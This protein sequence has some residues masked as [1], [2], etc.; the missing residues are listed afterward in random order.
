MSRA[1]RKPSKAPVRRQAASRSTAHGPRPTPLADLRFNAQ[2]LIAAIVQDAETGAVLMLGH[3]D[4]EALDATLATADVHFHSRSRGVLWRK[5]EASGN[6]LRLVAIAA[7]CD[8]DALLVQA[9]PAGPTCHTG[10]TSC[11]HRV[12][13]GTGDRGPGTGKAEPS[14]AFV[15]QNGPP[16]R[17]S[18]RGA[19]IAGGGPRNACPEPERG[20]RLGEAIS[21]KLRASASSSAAPAA[22]RTPRNDSGGDEMTSPTVPLGE[23]LSLA[24]LFAVLMDRLE[25]RP[26]GSYTVKLLDNEDKA[27][28][29]LIEEAGEVAL[30]VKNRD[31][32]NLVW[33]VADV[34]YHLAVIMVAQGIAPG[35]VNAELERRA[36]EAR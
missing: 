29:K 36:G 14:A 21:L 9:R 15:G 6:V 19:R 16:Q 18:L 35:D 26:E 5:G 8:G 31:R 10:A 27:L 20:R 32:E 23:G 4:R 17:P 30:A 28:K 22:P 7:D 2:G 34:L 3:M 13:Q 12:M 25:R 33:E 1:P 24:P 11:F